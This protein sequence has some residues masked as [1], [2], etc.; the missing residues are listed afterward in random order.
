[1]S[2][3]Y[4]RI[5]DLEKE[6]NDS[7]PLEKKIVVNGI[8]F[9]I[10]GGTPL[11][12]VA[13]EI[14]DATTY[15]ELV[16]A[17]GNR[18]HWLANGYGIPDGQS[19]EE[20]AKIDG[21]TISL[22]G[23]YTNSAGRDATEIVI[24]DS[25]G[26]TLSPY[27]TSNK[28]GLYPPVV[29]EL[30][31]TK[32]SAVSSGTGGDP[33][34]T[35]GGNSIPP[36]NPLSTLYLRIIDLNKEPNDPRPL[37]NVFLDGILITIDGGAPLLIRH[38]E[39]ADATT[40]AELVTA[41]G[42]RGHWLANGYGIP[43]G[44]SAVEYAKIDGIT[45]SL[46][47]EYTTAAGN[48]A[49]EIVIHD[50][51]GRDLASAG[52]T[53]KAGLHPT[54][55]SALAFTLSNS[56]VS[57]TGSDNSIIRE[58]TSLTVRMLDGLYIRDGVGP[59]ERLAVNG[60]IFNHDGNDIEVIDDRLFA[61]KT[62]PE[63]LNALKLRG[64]ELAQGILLPENADIK[65]YQKLVGFH[66]YL[67]NDYTVTNIV[68]NKV[69]GTEMI[70]SDPFRGE[71]S[72]PRF[73]FTSKPRPK[74]V[75]SIVSFDN[76]ITEIL[77]PDPDVDPDPSG[78][79]PITGGGSVTVINKSVLSVELIDAFS[80]RDGFPPLQRLN[81]NGIIFKRNGITFRVISNDIY[82]AHT[83]PEL[84][85]AIENRGS[86]LAQGIDIPPSGNSTEYAALALFTVR[87]GDPFII[88]NSD[89]NMIAGTEILISDNSGGELS[90]LEYS[91]G[92]PN[93]AY[94]DVEAYTG[95]GNKT[96][97]TNGST[98]RDPNVKTDW[99]VIIIEDPEGTEL[100]LSQNEQYVLRIQALRDPDY[101]DE[102]LGQSDSSSSG[103]STS[104][105]ILDPP[106]VISGMLAISGNINY[107]NFPNISDNRG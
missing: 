81:V 69:T 43:D 28:S 67:G 106:P 5:S 36:T 57:T 55:T 103:G 72:N 61:A 86:E 74:I 18:G 8:S 34:T 23:T 6:S 60:I 101:E 105:I 3:L 53:T 35:G 79:I 102:M 40:Y 44:Q 97:V 12:V 59:I 19:A 31:F 9:T 77:D 104:V 45:I 88:T 4:L 90:D 7:S 11:L 94:P 62:Y 68:G 93:I 49:T 99:G 71:L 95:G 76:T 51:R 10:D 48:T 25:R 70:I 107:P 17:I 32:T 91:F 98:P 100:S 13:D 50:S 65:V 89:G 37:E 84:L 56:T 29:M 42:N 66:I 63:F 75:D 58:A 87:L 96:T 78:D 80:L 26:R 52:S 47:H 1:M 14:A 39:I 22:G 30:D 82:N 15:A 73:S 33:P 85:Q 16:T 38:D 54:A 64:M 20:Y 41:I 2:T 27:G 21:I 83:Y 92:N 46:G 24:H